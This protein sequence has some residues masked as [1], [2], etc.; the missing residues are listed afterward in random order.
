MKEGTFDV[1]ERSSARKLVRAVRA[2]VGAVALT[3]TVGAC[4]VGGSVVGGGGTKDA[5][6]GAGT[7]AVSIGDLN[8]DNVKGT[9]ERALGS[10][11]D[12]FK[13]VDLGSGTTAIKFSEEWADE[14]FPADGADRP[15]TVRC[16]AG[17]MVEGIE[18]KPVQVDL[19]IS[20]ASGDVEPQGN[21]DLMVKGDGVTAG[22]LRYVQDHAKPG[23]DAA[24][25]SFVREEVLPKFK[26]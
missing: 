25:E 10:V 7:G 17:A 18:S 2:L 5:E 6:G 13:K 8:A 23:D 9:C 24:Y 14:Y 22:V 26:P 19:M 1:T 21:V 15:V 12:T 4:G 11:E 3:A 16:Q 20:V